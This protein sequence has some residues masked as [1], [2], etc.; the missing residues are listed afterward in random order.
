MAAP[1]EDRPVVV[2]GGPQMIT[3]QLP[4]SFKNTQA[5]RFVVEPKDMAVP[6]KS[7][8]VMNKGQKAFGLTL[9]S[10][11]WTITIE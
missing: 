2:G 5:G 4:A 9:D 8:V 11:D 10:T 7:I 6:F 3:I 1:G